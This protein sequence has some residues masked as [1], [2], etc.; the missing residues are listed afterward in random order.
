MSSFE[1]SDL[2]LDDGDRFGV[3]DIHP[4]RLLDEQEPG[5]AGHGEHDRRCRPLIG[6]EAITDKDV[7]QKLQ[8]SLAELA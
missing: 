4:E 8:F 6:I 2:S 7:G 5:D 3:A 1:S